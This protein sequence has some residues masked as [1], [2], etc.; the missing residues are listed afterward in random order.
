MALGAE[1]SRIVRA[2][3]RGPVAQT[4]IGLL[5]GT[6]LGIAASRSIAGQ[7]YGVDREAP[8]AFGAAAGVLLATT[9]IAAIFPAFRA[10][11]IDPA[12][13]LRIQ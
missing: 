1:R 13:A 5:L 7:L 11:S 3:V 9:V 8:I 12:Q 10:A 6:P 2:V 4:I